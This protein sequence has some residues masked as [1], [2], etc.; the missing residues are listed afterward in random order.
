[1]NDKLDFVGLLALARK[2]ADREIDLSW[3]PNLR[4]SMDIRVRAD[5]EELRKKRVVRKFLERICPIRVEE[6]E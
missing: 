2:E 4:C 3:P 6:A 5:V 1:M